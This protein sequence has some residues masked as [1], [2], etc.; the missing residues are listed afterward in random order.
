MKWIYIDKNKGK[1][2]AIVAGLLLAVLIGIRITITILYSLNLI[3]NVF[4]NFRIIICDF[5]LN[6]DQFIIISIFF[7]LYIIAD[8]FFEGIPVSLLEITAI[9]LILFLILQSGNLV[10]I[11]L[12][13]FSTARFALDLSILFLIVL[14]AYIIVLIF[15]IYIFWLKTMEKSETK[16]EKDMSE[17]KIK[18]DKGEVYTKKKDIVNFDKNRPSKSMFAFN[19]LARDEKWVD[20]K[21]GTLYFED[22]EYA[23]LKSWKEVE[24][25]YKESFFQF[26]VLN[27]L[28]LL[29]TGFI[30]GLI[31]FL[32][33]DIPA[34]GNYYN[35]FLT[36]LFFPVYTI[37]ITSFISIRHFVRAVF[38]LFGILSVTLMFWEMDLITVNGT[39]IFSKIIAFLNILFIDL[40][41]YFNQL[42]RQD[43]YNLYIFVIGIVIQIQFFLLIITSF[44]G[45]LRRKGSEMD[46]FSSNLYLYV[47]DTNI[48][49]SWMLI[50]EL[51]SVALWPFNPNKWRSLYNKLQFKLQSIREGTD[52]NY[53][54]LSYLKTI[55]KIKKIR[56]SLWKLIGKI[57]VLILLFAFTISYFF[58][59]IFLSIIIVEIWRFHKNKDKISIKAKY[60]RKKAQGSI[61][62]FGNTNVLYLYRL[63]KETGALIPSVQSYK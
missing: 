48:Y 19:L 17:G 25:E 36:G 4:N 26:F 6:Y 60:E 53:G 21:K 33:Q 52:F 7:G 28:I 39:F 8:G 18:K 63:S 46:I 45:Y 30:Y 54:R 15:E 37:L 62:L 24:G 34:E 10:F 29:G 27:I 5:S 56:P 61:F 23:L 14:I 44:I 32:L 2:F 22:D 43:L 1:F 40:A 20:P 55:K 50:F 42:T 38:F 41:P 58:G 9:I 12:I 59:Y 57:G 49:N 13:P 31:R 3:P 51:L 16:N 11:L 47:R 35:F